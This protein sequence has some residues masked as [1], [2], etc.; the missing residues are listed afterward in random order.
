MTLNPS[1]PF[2]D[3]PQTNKEV[4]RIVK[5][6]NRSGRLKLLHAEMHR[7]TK[8]F[9][10]IPKSDQQV[11]DESGEF[12]QEAIGCGCEQV[13]GYPTTSTTTTTNY[14]YSICIQPAYRRD[15]LRV[16]V[17]Y[18]ATMDT[19]QTDRR[20]YLPAQRVAEVFR[21]IRK[22]DIEILGKVLVVVVVVVEEEVGED[23]FLMA[24]FYHHY[25]YYH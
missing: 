24:R 12:T 3:L 23:Q 10:H 13:C 15:G 25:H 5:M 7:I 21:N 20:Q 18:P 8:K 1:I 17:T 2:N 6:R 19:V 11:V 16:M 22:E 9:C 4:E 14:N